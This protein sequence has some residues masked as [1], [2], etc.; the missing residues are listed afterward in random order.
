MGRALA[1]R[2][3]YVDVK[4]RLSFARLSRRQLIA[5]S[6]AGWMGNGLAQQAGPPHDI[7]RSKTAIPPLK[8]LARFP[9]GCCIA[10]PY[11]REAAYETL[12]LQ[13]FSQVTAE[14]EMKMN[15]VLGDD[16]TYRFEAPDALVD[17]ARRAGLALHGHALIWFKHAPVGIARLDGGGAAF[18]R[19]YDDHIA[20]LVGRYRGRLRGWDVIN[21][22]IQPDGEGLRVSLFSRNLGDEAHMARAFEVAR[23]ADPDA[24]LFL[25][26][27]DL[28]MKPEK[29]RAFLRLVERLLARGVPLGGLGT[30]SHLSLA[31][32]PGAARQALADLAGFGLPIHVSE[33]DISLGR[34]RLDGAELAGARAGQAR[35]LEEVLNAFHDLPP[36][37]QYAITF[38]GLRDAD[39]WWRK[40]PLN[41]AHDEPVL[42]DD[43]GGAKK[44]AE[45]AAASLA[46]A[47]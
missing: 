17:F 7:A 4:P 30:Q 41:R 28:E 45:T 16:G 39:S 10:R 6:I 34:H 22:P 32:R 38:W 33:L 27:Y 46:R 42:F 3:R 47:R 15:Q 44:L 36:A 24:V 5:A 19:A 12:L 43:G 31:M 25:N 20:G 13:Q 8:S 18:E 37:Q 21:E 9:L 26:D 1:F 35:I 2:A 23:Q 29:R 40:P 14:W 11:L